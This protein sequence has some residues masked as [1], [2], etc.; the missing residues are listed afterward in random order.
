M[1][2]ATFTCMNDKCAGKRGEKRQTKQQPDTLKT[3]PSC[4]KCFEPMSPPAQQAKTLVADEFDA[5]AARV[6][7]VCPTETAAHKYCRAVVAFLGT[8]EGEKFQDD[9]KAELKK[10]IDF[11][12]FTA[13]NPARSQAAGDVCFDSAMTNAECDY[14]EG[15]PEGEKFSFECP[16]ILKQAGWTHMGFCKG[17]KLL[18]AKFSDF[19]KNAQGG[20]QY[21]VQWTQV[22]KN[23]ESH[24]ICIT[25]DTGGTSAWIYDP[26]K[27][28]M[29]YASGFCEAWSSPEEGGA[30]LSP[31]CRLDVKSGQLER[32]TD[33]KKHN[34]PKWQ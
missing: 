17:A 16:Y 2:L 31:K 11:G 26:Q 33:P 9:F 23:T 3:I 10:A 20:R 13:N 6:R 34:Q 24:M 29:N 4:P 22:A 5:L 8:D 30:P 18:T 25:V 12:K 14:P 32:E 21:L 7:Q 15:C 1:G 28:N 19:L 27:R